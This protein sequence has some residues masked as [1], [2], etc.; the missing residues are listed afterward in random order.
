MMSNVDRFRD[1]SLSGIAAVHRRLGTPGRLPDRTNAIVLYHSVGQGTTL[2]GNVSAERLRRDLEFLTDA[3]EVVDLPAV[4]G[5]P[6]AGSSKK[7]ALTFDDGY[8]N[9]YTNARPLLAEF[10]VP[11]T[12][13]VS[14]AFVD[15]QNEELLSRRHGIEPSNRDVMMTTSQL[16]E[17]AS[18]RRITVGNHTL[19]HPHLTNLSSKEEQK[20]EI[21][22]GKRNLERM[23]EA[24]VDRFSYPYGDYDGTCAE[25]VGRTH[26]TAVSTER[27]LLAEGVDELAL[28]RIPAHIPENLFRL[29][30]TDLGHRCSSV[31]RP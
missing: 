17:L 6:A 9:F 22:E 20:T 28:P 14:P 13:Y 1:A 26:D 27:S 23:L 12:V 24:S 30:V 19:S 5:D 25:I 16:R 2:F 21:V 7:I 8:K 18:S 10:D 11:A 29:E 15:D 31:L 3:Y 4:V